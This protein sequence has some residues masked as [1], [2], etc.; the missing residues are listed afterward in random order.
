MLAVARTLRFCVLCTRFPEEKA[1]AVKG[2]NSRKRTALIDATI[3]RVHVFVG[4]LVQIS[5]R[6]NGA[7]NK[8][9]ASVEAGMISALLSR[10]KLGAARMGLS[11]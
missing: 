6:V 7:P 1:D 11:V 2:V 4:L 8:M 5:R 10:S 9:A 3:E